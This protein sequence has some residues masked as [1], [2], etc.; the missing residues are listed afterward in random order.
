ML[1]K[2]L[3]TTG[4]TKSNRLGNNRCLTHG[5]TGRELVRVGRHNNWHKAKMFEQHTMSHPLGGAMRPRF[6]DEGLHREGLG[7]VL[8]S[9]G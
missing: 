8:E 1:V 7:D 3:R 4:D 5:A 2:S 9:A 6:V